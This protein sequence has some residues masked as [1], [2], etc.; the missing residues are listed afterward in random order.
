MN[1]AILFKILQRQ[2]KF[3]N[4]KNGLTIPENF[5]YSSDEF[6]TALNYL[7]DLERLKINYTFPGD[8]NYPHAFY[9]MIEPP[10]FLEY[11]GQPVWNSLPLFSVVGSRKIHSLSVLWMKEHLKTLLANSNYRIASGGAIGVDLLSHTISVMNSQPT[12]AILPSGLS[13]LSPMDFRRLAPAVIRAGGALLSEFEHLSE[14][15]KEYFFFR[16][17]LI[18]A[19]GALTL[20]VQA[21]NRSGTFLTVHH[22][23]QNGRPVMAVP[24]HPSIEC[25]SGNLILLQDGAISASNEAEVRMYL[26]TEIEFNAQPQQAYSV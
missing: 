7:K 5:V 10:L 22:A 15:R 2:N 9:K 26:Q 18:A 24:T 16:N 12:V 1:K 17:R 4:P 23:L 6:S 8:L 14:P 21:Q 25:F 3:R 11:I 20:V 19:M 13:K